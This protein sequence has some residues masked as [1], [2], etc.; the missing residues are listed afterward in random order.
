[1]EDKDFQARF[2]DRMEAVQDR[3]AE[4][5]AAILSR[6]KGQAPDQLVYR[7]GLGFR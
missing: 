1:M 6:R 2:K 4:S 3:T 5:Q 7:A